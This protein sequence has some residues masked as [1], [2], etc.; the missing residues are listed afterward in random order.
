MI[1]NHKYQCLDCPYFVELAD[2]LEL[3]PKINGKSQTLYHF[4][5]SSI[6]DQTLESAYEHN[7][8][9][10]HPLGSHFIQGV[11][12]FTLDIPDKKVIWHPEG[13]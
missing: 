10:G 5:T 8:I 1:V 2:D 9:T 4:A 7:K 11:R 12:V 3:A 6:M 13:R